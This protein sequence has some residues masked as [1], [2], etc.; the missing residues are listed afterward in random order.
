MLWEPVP[1]PSI[2]QRRREAGLVT[3]EMAFHH[4]NCSFQQLTLIKNKMLSVSAE[5]KPL[6]LLWVCYRT[7][8][9][10]C[11]IPLRT[12]VQYPQQFFSSTHALHLSSPNRRGRRR[13]GTALPAP[14]K[15]PH[16]HTQSQW[17]RCRL[18][19]GSI[20][21]EEQRNQSH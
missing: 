15:P 7:L 18:L 17:V 16:T 8:P 5:G 3:R 12:D 14:I 1:C 10:C 21:M 6:S 11:S 9:T 13:G 20:S 2:T 4:L 19:Q